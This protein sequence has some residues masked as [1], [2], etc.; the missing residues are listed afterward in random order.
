MAKTRS[1][2]ITEVLDQ[3]GVL[4]AGQTPATEDV[5]KV[6]GKLNSVLDEISALDIITIDDPGSVGPTGGE[7]PSE[8]FLAL[9][10][11]IANRC[12][13][14]FGLAGDPALDALSKRAEKTLRT[15]VRPQRARRTLRTDAALRGARSFPGRGSFS[16]GT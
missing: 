14:S 7:I 5:S 1:E 6:D 15:I 10:T 4:A 9:G 11:V 16:N 3:L 12:A 8:A 2:L 13:P